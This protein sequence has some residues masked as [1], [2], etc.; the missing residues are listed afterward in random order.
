MLAVT[1]RVQGGVVICRGSRCDH[2]RGQGGRTGSVFR[3][4][5]RDRVNNPLIRTLSDSLTTVPL[6]DTP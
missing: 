2:R 4:P 3:Q 6:S 5:S 1:T